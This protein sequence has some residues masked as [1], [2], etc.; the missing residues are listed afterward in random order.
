MRALCVLALICGV[1]V[2]R[3]QTVT[4][5]G[6]FPDDNLT[7]DSNWLGGVAPLNDGSEDLAFPSNSSGFLVLNVT[8]KFKSITTEGETDS[9]ATLSGAPLQ[10]GT[11]GIFVNSGSGSSFLVI[12]SD[13]AFQTPQMWVVGAE[14]GSLTVNGA[15]TGAQPLTFTGDGF[16]GG[17]N[18]TNPNSTFG[19]ATHGLTLSGSTT[20]LLVGSSSV[21][22]SPALRQVGRWA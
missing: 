2:A 17:L 9:G 12:N 7:T 6:G 5:G 13:V 16:D 3:S 19:D 20:I 10:I 4:W 22:A 18:L 1:P 14:G 15:I 8:G 21:G 11:G